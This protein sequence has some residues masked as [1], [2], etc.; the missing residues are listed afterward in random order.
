MAG[1]LLYM[2]SA[3]GTVV[4]LDPATG[5]VVWFDVPPH[6]EGKPPRARR[7]DARRRVL[8]ERKR[9]PHLRHER[10]ESHRAQREDRQALSRLGHE[11]PDRSHEGR[12]R[13]RRRH[14]LPQQQRPDRRPR[15]RRRRRRAGSRDGL[16]E[17]AREGDEGSAA[18]RH[19]RVRREDRQAP[20]DVPRRAARR[21]VRRRHVAER[22]ARRTRGTAACGR[23]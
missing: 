7:L 23:C 20:L 10:P 9:L 12:L 5:K 2:S 16:P 14:R 22:I 11:R 17:R 15:R 13:P 3:V 1:G 19:P 18:R 6:E 8:G 21:R 4:A